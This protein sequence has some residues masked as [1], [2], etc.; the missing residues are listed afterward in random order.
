[1]CVRLAE[2]LLPGNE[3][4]TTTV[5]T[6]VAH[7]LPMELCS[8]SWLR[9]HYPWATAKTDKWELFFAA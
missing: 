7:K 4:T 2:S 1:M 8:L 3:N 6:E 5:Y 9:A